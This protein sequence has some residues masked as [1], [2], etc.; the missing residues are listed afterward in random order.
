MTKANT[1]HE[2]FSKQKHFG[3]PEAQPV[4]KGEKVLHSNANKT[5]NNKPKTNI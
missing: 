3:G 4:I 1:D 2:D 5:P